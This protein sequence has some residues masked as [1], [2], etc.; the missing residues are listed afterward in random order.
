[1]VFTRGLQEGGQGL[2]G[3]A[4]RPVLGEVRLGVVSSTQCHGTSQ[5]LKPSLSVPP[6]IIWSNMSRGR[7]ENCEIGPSLCREPLVY[8]VSGA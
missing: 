6:S 8:G 5:G 1:M 2:A 3:T 4:L 7:E